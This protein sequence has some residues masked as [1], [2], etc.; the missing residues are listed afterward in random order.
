MDNAVTNTARQDDEGHQARDSAGPEIHRKI[1]RPDRDFELPIAPQRD[2]IAQLLASKTVSPR[3]VSGFLAILELLLL[4]VAGGASI[5]IAT[6]GDV[7]AAFSQGIVLL[8]FTLLYFGLGQGLQIY[9]IP[10]L[11]DSAQQFTLVFALWMTCFASLIVV[12]HLFPHA[13]MFNAAWISPFFISGLAVII[14]LRFPATALVRSWTASGLLERRAIIVGGGS[15]AEAVIHDLER[16][17]N[18]DIRICGIFDDRTDSRSPES[19]AGYPKLGTVA[20]LVDF[21]RITRLD[22]LIVTLPLTASG[23][24]RE[25]LKQ[26]WVLPL[27][28]RLSAHTNKIG[29]RQRHFS[30]EGAIPF[31]KLSDRPI[32][33]WHSVRKRIFDIV[34]SSL[35]LVTLFPLMAVTAVAIKLDSRGPVFF[36]QKR[37][38]FN[39][40][41]IDVWKFRSMYTDLCDAEAKVVVT[42]EDPR[43]TRVGRFIR[44]TSIDE[45]PQ[46]WN[47]LK[48]ELSLVGPRP[49]AVHAHLKNQPWN[50]VVDGYFARHRVKPGVTGWAQINGWRGEVDNVEKLKQRTEHDLYYIENWSLGFDL[51]ILALTPLRLLDTKNAY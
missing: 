7:S 15:E 17:P 12:S 33:G 50:D 35:A 11:R 22:M 9:S 26:L 16:Q 3:L 40:E 1:N 42:K 31:I 37:H 28:I 18:N 41:L 38:G 19:V 6:S 25:M 32:K 29:F 23:R 8:S 10:V 48:G 27:D 13:S 4:L 30:Y 21:A 24:V 34:V 44:K 14:A 49:H 45:L 5:T 39:N 36:R 20:E 43:V 46:L 51:Y 47:V 2:D